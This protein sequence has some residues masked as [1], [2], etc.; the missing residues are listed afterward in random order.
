MPNMSIEQ[1]NAF[2]QEVRIATLVTLDR[3]GAPV[4]VPVW[5]EWDG[6]RARL[7]TSRDSRKVTRIRDDARVSLSVAE[8]VGVPEAWVSIEGMATVEQAGG[9]AL[10]ERLARRYYTAEKAA[11]VLP[12]WERLASQWV[13]IVIEPSRI[14][15]SAPE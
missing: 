13:V 15:S 12:G 3:A 10:A 6:E 14:R 1:R 8:P 9:F 11:A 7:F 2:L 5:Y 4:P